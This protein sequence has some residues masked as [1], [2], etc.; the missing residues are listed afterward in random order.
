MVGALV[1]AALLRSADAKGHGV[2]KFC[3]FFAGEAQVSRA[4]HDAQQPGVSFDIKYQGGSRAMDIMLAML[5]VLRM[6]TNSLAVL[7]PVCSSF[8]FMCVSQ[9][10]RSFE[11]PAGRCHDVPWVAL[12]NKMAARSL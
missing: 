9:S 2:W 4:L 12:S 8:T 11:N 1:R 6:D 10:G 5:G 7:A 3:E